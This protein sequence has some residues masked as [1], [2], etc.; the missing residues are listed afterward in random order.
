MYFTTDDLQPENPQSENVVIYNSILLSDLILFVSD[1]E[2]H[3]YQIIELSEKSSEDFVWIRNNQLN[4]FA[5]RRNAFMRDLF[6]AM[7]IAIKSK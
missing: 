7:A 6:G 4:D 5:I 1:S 3:F 2:I